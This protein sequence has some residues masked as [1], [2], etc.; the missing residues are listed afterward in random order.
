MEQPRQQK[1]DD[2]WNI[3]SV[4]RLCSLKTVARELVKYELP[5]LGVKEAIWDKGANEQAENFYGN[6]NDDNHLWTGI[7]RVC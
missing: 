4:C 1:L 5:L 7:K 3:R 6:G 2:I